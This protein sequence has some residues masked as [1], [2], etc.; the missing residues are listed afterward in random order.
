MTGATALRDATTRRLMDAACEL[1]AVQ[2]LD[3]TMRDVAA[4]AG[5]VPATAYNHFSSRE[6]L[7]AE[8]Y[9][10][11]VARLSDRLDAR[12]PSG[13]DPMSRVTSVIR[14]ATDGVA[15][16]PVLAAAFTLA[17]ASADP[18]VAAVRPRIRSSFAHWLD[19]ALADADLRDRDVIVTTLERTM[20]AGMI[21]HAHGTL[22]VARLRA[23][24]VATA[25]VLLRGGRPETQESTDD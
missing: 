23:D 3:F 1:A 2:G 14:R 7:L 8:V 13:A 20:Y 9:A 18:A 5:V 6:H 10:D 16:A 4:A 15:E 25:R 11:W 12:P 21:S 22:S 24:L 17:L 19:I